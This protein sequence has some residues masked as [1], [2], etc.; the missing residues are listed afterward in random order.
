LDGASLSYRH[1]RTGEWAHDLRDPLGEAR[2]AFV[3]PAFEAR[4]PS[5]GGRLRIL[6]IGFGRGLNT[7]VA[8]QTLRGL[9][10]AR[11][12]SA[13]ECLGL[14]PHPEGLEPW[15]PPPDSIQDSCPWWGGL[16][17]PW[18]LPD[19]SRW[20]GEIL[21]RP[22]PT[23]L[24]GRGVFDWI[25]LDLYSPARHPED[26]D[27]GLGPA[28]AAIAR[29]GSVLTSYCCARFLRDLLEA[30]GWVVERLRA[31]HTRDTLRALYP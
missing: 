8:L 5:P 15:P 14:E 12:P 25:F 28:L 7:A 1:P 24:R 11:Q 3:D 18:S 13:V 10:S 26:W 19:R 6:E 23:G 20:R 29:P 31:R 2:G 16:P 27:P 4:P 9:V 21:S 30:Q 22:A 17:G